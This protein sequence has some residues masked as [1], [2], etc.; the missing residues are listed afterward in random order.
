[1]QITGITQSGP[2]PGPEVDAIFGLRQWTWAFAAVSLLLH[3][4]LTL[5]TLPTASFLLSSAPD[6]FASVCLQFSSLGFVWDEPS[7]PL[8]FSAP[9]LLLSFLCRA[10]L[11]ESV[12]LA[13][14]QPAVIVPRE[15]SR[16]DRDIIPREDTHERNGVTAARPYSHVSA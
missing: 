7:L 9:S 13:G 5:S 3:L 12:P 1:M 15:E 10:H 14:S 8:W 6:D 11:H 2:G 4:H 16:L